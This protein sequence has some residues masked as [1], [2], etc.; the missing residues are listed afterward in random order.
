MKAT[1]QN[2]MGIAALASCALGVLMTVQ[3]AR[4]M[5]EA[6]GQLKR[7]AADYA[8][9]LAL[10]ARQEKLAAAQG[11][12]EGLDRKRAVPMADL[13][14]S[15]L[16]GVRA[17]VRPRDATALAGGWSLRA[18]DVTL[19]DVDF[20]AVSRWLVAAAATRPPWRVAEI[21]VAASERPGAGRVNLM[22]EVVEKT[23]N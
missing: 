15:E 4:A 16:P 5:P 13:V 6:A 22:M 2:I 9:L 3:S 21:A 14:Q 20:S 17:E 11:V 10:A 12:F 19:E 18:A 1:R 7:R 23:G 8:K